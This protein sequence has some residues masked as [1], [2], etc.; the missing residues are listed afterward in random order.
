M[1]RTL[2]ITSNKEYVNPIQQSGKSW[3][4]DLAY[5]RIT[6]LRLFNQPLSVYNTRIRLI[7]QEKIKEHKRTKESQLKNKL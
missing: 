3:A 7:L 2:K 4:K 1:I 5:F 6:D